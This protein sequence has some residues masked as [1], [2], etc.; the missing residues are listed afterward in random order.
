[1]AL[2]LGF[3]ACGNGFESTRLFKFVSDSR[4]LSLLSIDKVPLTKKTKVLLQEKKTYPTNV[5]MFGKCVGEGVP[6]EDLIS[7]GSCV[8]IRTPSFCLEQAKQTAPW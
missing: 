7:Y 3:R 5:L 1:M 6:L 2:R 8:L 4:N